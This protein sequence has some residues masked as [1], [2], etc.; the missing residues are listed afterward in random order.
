MEEMRTCE[1]Y[2]VDAFLEKCNRTQLINI[3]K[4]A[5]YIISYFG[6]HY[7]PKR[8]MEFF[9]YYKLGEFIKKQKTRIAMEKAWMST[10]LN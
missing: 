7:E 2:E 3:T 6:E 8:A 1:H 4:D 10:Y 5:M 9:D